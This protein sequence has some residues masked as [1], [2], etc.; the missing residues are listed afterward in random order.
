MYNKP[1]V[2]KTPRSLYK[3]HIKLWNYIIKELKKPSRE[4]IFICNLKSEAFKKFG[5]DYVLNNCFGCEWV[6]KNHNHNSQCSQHCLFKYKNDKSDSCLGGLWFE[7]Y[8][9]PNKEKQIK[10]AE[11]I[12]DLPIKPKWLTKITEFS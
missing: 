10:I 2:F 1:K 4:F 8:N 7:V 6:I 11:Q 3:A 9:S 12:R 5:W